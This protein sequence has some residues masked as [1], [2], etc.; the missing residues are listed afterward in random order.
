ME[1][2]VIY[3]AEHVE[4]KAWLPFSTVSMECAS[5]LSM[6]GAELERFCIEVVKWL[7]NVPESILISCLSQ[8]SQE[9]VIKLGSSISIYRI[10][11]HVSFRDINMNQN[12]Y[13]PWL[14]SLLN[15]CATGCNL[16]FQIEAYRPIYRQ[17]IADFC[18]TS[19]FL[20]QNLD[21]SQYLEF[22]GVGQV[23]TRT[24]VPTK[25]T[26][27]DDSA[28][29]FIKDS[30]RRLVAPVM[31]FRAIDMLRNSYSGTLTEESREKFRFDLSRRLFNETVFEEIEEVLSKELTTPLSKLSIFVLRV[32]EKAPFH[33][34]FCNA[35]LSLY[36]LFDIR[37]SQYISRSQI[38]L[39]LDNEL[40]R[41]TL[42]YVCMYEYVWLIL[43]NS[44]T[45]SAE[46]HQEEVCT[47][48]MVRGSYVESFKHVITTIY[49]KK[50]QGAHETSFGYTSHNIS[51]PLAV[52]TGRSAASLSPFQHMS[53]KIKD[54]T[55]ILKRLG[56]SFTVPAQESPASIQSKDTAVSERASSMQV[57]SSSRSTTNKTMDTD[58][59]I[60]SSSFHSPPIQHR[61]V[62]CDN[63]TLVNSS[64]LSKF[65]QIEAAR[66]K[67]KSNK[68][69]PGKF[70]ILSIKRCDEMFWNI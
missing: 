31:N 44:L 55:S 7:K 66:F 42:L 46:E 26:Q 35:L 43:Q 60:N 54:P 52:S 61:L 21:F 15:R 33:N 25:L 14:K 8:Q 22:L 29:E 38:S 56:F 69:P 4:A 5:S 45:D 50:Q 53:G 28:K 47:T 70:T 10:T 65:A 59:N 11:C 67:V 27:L 64:P 51:K 63:F 49:H 17:T 23:G 32:C 12:K 48:K 36:G 19:S 68:R 37:H 18:T 41:C 6:A 40:Y 24:S 9:D 34:D 1:L 2:Y 13:L 39:T 57:S 20:V 16:I 30:F 58:P 62:R 3:S